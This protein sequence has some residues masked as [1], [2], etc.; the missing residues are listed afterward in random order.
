MK[1]IARRIRRLE[2][3]FLPAPETEYSR[4]LRVRIEEGLRRVREMR[5]RY[6]GS[7]PIDDLPDPTPADASNRPRGVVEIL[8]RGLERVHL[9]HLQDQARQRAADRPD[10]SAVKIESEEHVD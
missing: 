9:K 7:A 8:N 6:G 10:N 5:Q 4:L 3:R 1:S 2:E